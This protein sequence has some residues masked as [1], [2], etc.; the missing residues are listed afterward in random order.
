MPHS[1]YKGL[2]YH[3]HTSR[4][5]YEAYRRGLYGLYAEGFKVQILQE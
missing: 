2:A 4:E 1:S 3:I 5:E